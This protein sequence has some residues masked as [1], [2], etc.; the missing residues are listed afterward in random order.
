MADS[1]LVLLILGCGQG[2]HQAVHS[3]APS[4]ETQQKKNHRFEN[5]LGLGKFDLAKRKELYPSLEDQRFDKLKYLGFKCDKDRK[6]FYVNF[7]S[8]I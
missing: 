8:Q 5:F 6:L 2:S 4:D 3:E 1:M 7:V